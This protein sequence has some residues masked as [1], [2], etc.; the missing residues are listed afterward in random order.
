MSE[1]PV[2]LEMLEAGHVLAVGT[3]GSGKTYLLRGLLEQL[4]EAGRRVGA[5]DKLGNHWGL[6][7]DANGRD[8]GLEFVIFGGRQPHAVPMSPRDGA[9][10]GRIFVERNVP[11]IFDVSQWKPDE[12]EAWV[13]DFADAVFEANYGRGPLHLSMD[14]AQSW[15]PQGAKSEALGS[16][17][18]LI[19]QGRGNGVLLLLAVQRLARLDIT[20]RNLAAGVV[21][22]RQTGVADR[23]AVVDLVGGQ[24][25]DVRALS[26]ELPLLETGEGFV[27]NPAAKA[28][29]RHR[30]PPNRTFD[31]SR[32]P[33]HGEAPAAPTPAMGP[34]VE[35][36]RAL[37]APPAHEPG[38]A[39]ATDEEDRAESHD[40]D[41]LLAE[42][43]ARIA[44]LEEQL[45][46]ALDGRH[47]VAELGAR[48]H[49]A[50][51][52][53][54]QMAL[55]ESQAI[56]ADMRKDLELPEPD[57]DQMAEPPVSPAGTRE[58]AAGGGGDAPRPAASASVRVTGDAAGEHAPV[59]PAAATDGLEP[60]SS[61]AI[62]MAG[63][64]KSDPDRWWSWPE[65][66][67]EIVRRPGS[68]YLGKAKK[69]IAGRGWVWTDNQD[70]T[71]RAAKRLIEA[72][73]TAI[74]PLSRADLIARWVN[75]LRGP[76]GALLEELAAGGPGTREDLGRR[77]GKA[78]TSG[79]F[80]KGVKDLIG[81]NLAFVAG[82]GRVTLNQQLKDAA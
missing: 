32:T 34:L 65:L 26:A 69:A 1:R 4:R 59:A 44:E 53:V 62:E 55:A 22:L 14:E 54:G 71:L 76:G 82:D 64:L 43:D 28:L 19:E 23:K 13:A 40:R 39:L 9:R 27:W 20:T 70:G 50:L 42:R 61:A 51:L 72:S 68:G 74:P 31:S 6:T 21:A 16:V 11:A 29:G 17:R 75:E 3:T 8:P 7:L 79:W 45:A 63:L 36:L 5:I 77:I 10:L 48:A 46:H 49:R 47:R 38:E 80:G 24:A 41:A 60:L 15:A 2:T 37:L 78:H 73:T 52:S 58:A 57:Q 12:Q 18:R 35:E 30:F 81:S 67:L 33:K 56:L 25:P 66:A